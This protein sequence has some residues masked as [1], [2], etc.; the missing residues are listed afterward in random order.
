MHRLQQR[1]PLDAPRVPRR[2]VCAAG[3]GRASCSCWRRIRPLVA[4]ATK[5]DLRQLGPVELSAADLVPGAV[6]TS[7]TCTPAGGKVAR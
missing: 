4:S 1:E 5:P 6:K 3:N 2:G 7:L